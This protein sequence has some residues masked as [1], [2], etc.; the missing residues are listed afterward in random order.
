MWD[1]VYWSE[2]SGERVRECKGLAV[3]ALYGLD[4]RALKGAQQLA[5]GRNI[6][7]ESIN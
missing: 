7:T 5:F 3:Q 6:Q 1:T 4:Q 2:R